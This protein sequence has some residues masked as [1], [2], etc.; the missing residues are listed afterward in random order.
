[1]LAKSPHRIAEIPVQTARIIVRLGVRKREFTHVKQV[2]V[3]D[4][5]VGNNLIKT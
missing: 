4:I 5:A 1:M 3:L 2:T